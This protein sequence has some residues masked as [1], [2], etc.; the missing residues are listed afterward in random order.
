MAHRKLERFAEL[1]TFTN[2]YY[3][4][5]KEAFDDSFPMKGKWNTDCFK[6]N[7]PIVLELGCG[8]GEYT[9]KLAERE[10]EVNYI[11]IDIKGNRIWRGAKTAMENQMKNAAFLR[12]RIDFIDKA[13]G[14]G[15]V[16]EIWITFPDPQKERAR[17][18][19]TH[20]MFL[21]RYRQIL[22]PGGSVHLKTD[23]ILLHRY[24]LSVIR[25]AQL[26]ILDVTEDLYKDPGERVAAAGI[27]TFYEKLYLQKG[28]PITYL[29]FSL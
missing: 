21:D 11:G 3:L 19:L 12:T 26:K 23:S 28:C 1:E 7:N 25:D 22:K 29:K 18:R 6:N 4:P 9:V 24:T 13:F 8:K 15:E 14:A 16:N 10:K 20:P 27:Q 5:Y 17:K 2:S